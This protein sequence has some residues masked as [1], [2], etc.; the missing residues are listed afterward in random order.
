MPAVYNATFQKFSMCIA[1]SVQ[2]QSWQRVV[3]FCFG[4]HPRETR[5]RTPHAG[6]AGSIPSPA[7]R[8]SKL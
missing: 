5:V 4:Q 3:L 6:D 8:D 1:Q 2:C 7:P